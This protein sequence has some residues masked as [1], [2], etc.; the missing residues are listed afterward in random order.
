ME[1]PSWVNWEAYRPSK[2][3]RLFSFGYIFLITVIGLSF[4]WQL[5]TEAEQ[6][7]VNTCWL[8]NIVPNIG[9]WAIVSSALI[10]LH[11]SLKSKN[12]ILLWL[13]RFSLLSLR[14]LVYLFFGFFIWNPGANTI[15][16][17][18]SFGQTQ[19]ALV[20]LVIVFLSEQLLKKIFRFINNRV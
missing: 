20:T 10:C 18:C 11:L 9:I 6:S 14:S 13:T 4:L 19:I 5:F 12:F 7:N 1:L 3:F 2:K 8:D 17:L 16:L 15:E